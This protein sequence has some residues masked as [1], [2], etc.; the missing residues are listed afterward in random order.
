MIQ[1]SQHASN[2]ISCCFPL[3]C[4]LYRNVFIYA[5]SAA[6]AGGG[7]G[8]VKHCYNNI[9]II[10]TPKLGRDH[11][12]KSVISLLCVKSRMI[13]LDKQML[14]WIMNY[15]YL[16]P[17]CHCSSLKP[18]ASISP[19]NDKLDIKFSSAQN[20]YKYSMLRM[21][22]SLVHYFFFFPPAWIS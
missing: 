14:Q 3:G 17:K 5:L 2:A 7:G 12:I 4:F 13:S 10:R 15:G 8:L 1:W 19:H 6:A 22:S 11:Q 9:S 18:N 16:L 20:S 21:K